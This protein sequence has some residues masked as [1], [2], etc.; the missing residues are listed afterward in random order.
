M[1]DIG[2]GA[3]RGVDW[4]KKTGF[5]KGKSMSKL[6]PDGEYLFA[7]ERFP[8]D[9]MVMMEVPAETTNKCDIG[10]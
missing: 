10:V 1:T 9:R 3:L 7:D 6:L 2:A 4:R 5:P 8:L